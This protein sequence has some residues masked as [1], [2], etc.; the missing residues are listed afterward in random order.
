MRVRALDILGLSQHF[1]KLNV[2]VEQRPVGEAYLTE[3]TTVCAAVRR[4][5]GGASPAQS[6][7][8]MRRRGPRWGGTL[9][10]TRNESHPVGW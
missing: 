4:L 10:D 7:A 5:T 6:P 2:E 9:P 3:G 1:K 8:S